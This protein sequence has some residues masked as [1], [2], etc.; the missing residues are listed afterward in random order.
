MIF[1]IFLIFFSL[2]WFLRQ[3]KSITFWLYLWQLKEYHIGRFAD[4]F[5]TE[6]GKKIF[7]NKVFILKILLFFI[8]IFSKENLICYFL[9]LAIFI[10]ESGKFL[11]DFL[12]G[13][14]LLPKFTLKI[15]FLFFANL[16]FTIFYFLSLLIPRIGFLFWLVIFDILNFGIISSLV[17]IFQMPTALSKKVIL[18]KAKEKR[19]EFKNITVVGITG[20]YGK[21]STK[22][23]LSTILSEKFKIL[24]TKEHQNS[25]MAIAKTILENLKKEHQIFICEMGA[26]NKGGIKRLVEI[27]KPQIGI[28]TGVTFQHL[29]L[30]GSLG[31]LISAEGG[32]ELID[33]LPED[34][35]L[36]FN[37]ENETLNEIQK[38][39][40]KRKKIVGINKKD[41]DLW[42]ENIEVFKNKLIFDA[43]FQTNEKIKIEAN[44]IG[45]Q[46][47]QNLLLAICCAKEL[48]MQ[49]KDIQSACKKISPIQGGVKLIEMEKGPDVIDSTYSANPESVLFH[50]E[51]LRLWKGKKAIVMPCLIE[52]G[53]KSQEIHQKIGRKIG[54]I[55]DLAI[56]TTRDFFE[57]IKK[58]ALKES[59]NFKKEK[60]EIFFIEN[61]KEILKK[62]K[63]LKEKENVI[64]FE[65]RV[66]F[67]L[68]I[69]FE[70]F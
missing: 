10:L 53:E 15:T 59:L 37:G 55:C 13:R 32:K 46:N 48:G 9:F 8:L 51:H 70:N 61:Q 21:T 44:L 25:E 56:I 43:C 42:A 17:L 58:S 50:L 2:F 39:V 34:G 69:F 29:S 41:F 57:D 1:K 65:G 31:N 7:L 60:I 27:A 68:N 3:I 64:L 5:R 63:T 18:R 26:Y 24:K 4:H 12:L 14:A 52:L 67:D 33:G 54:E 49:P 66:N 30:F 22:E 6:K 40:K 28:I 11:L 38:T 35:L 20:S 47:I 36:I 16:I 62:L 19:K 23:F 45:I